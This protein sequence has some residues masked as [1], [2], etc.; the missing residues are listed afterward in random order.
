MLQT[1][2][3]SGD[4]AC[5]VEL[6]RA[7]NVGVFSV[8]DGSLDTPVELATV[9]ALPGNIK[10]VDDVNWCANQF[11]SSYI[12]C[13]QTPG[14]SFI[15]ERFTA[16]QE[17]ILW[18][19]EYGH[20]TGLPHNPNINF[21]MYFSIGSN[22]LRVTN[23]ECTSYGGTAPA[24]S[25]TLGASLS[26]D[27]D[28]SEEVTK[29]PLTILAGAHTVY[30]EDGLPP[31]DEFV[32]QIY[33]EGLPLDLAAE[34]GPEDAQVL[35]GMLEDDKFVTYHENIALTLGMIG[36]N[37]ASE[38]LIGYV[39]KGGVA[40]TEE[41]RR[42]YKGV[43]GAIVGLGYLANQTSDERAVDYLID[44]ARSAPAQNRMA[45][46]SRE[47]GGSTATLSAELSKYALISLGLSGQEKAQS[48]LRQVRQAP[49]TELNLQ[50]L[51]RDVE[52]VLEQSLDLNSTIQPQGIQQYYRENR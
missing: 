24:T 8:T 32:T 39:D 17:G 22:R 7:G 52:G 43:V 15:T 11:N 31:V 10:V 5:N 14:P 42:A 47:A 18:A 26:V 28:K 25:G 3:G 29:P 51:P 40:A 44:T 30:E 41:T 13:G 27:P 46:L 9:F 6:R 33:F 21:V 4:T 48:F 20:N 19:H 38:V 50:A 12:G 23:T 34:Y 2:N 1:A 37:S 45:R 49:R 16:S 35:I 36:D